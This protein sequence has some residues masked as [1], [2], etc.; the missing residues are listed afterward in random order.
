MSQD[1]VSDNYSQG[2]DD[3][4]PIDT[5]LMVTTSNPQHVLS[6]NS[7]SSFMRPSETVDDSELEQERAEEEEEGGRRRRMGGPCSN[8]PAP[9]P[10]RDR[11]RAERLV[12]AWLRGRRRQRRRRR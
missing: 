8:Q 6:P 12:V 3:E 1:T 11:K 4:T 2:T 5:H 7:L 9:A 10:V